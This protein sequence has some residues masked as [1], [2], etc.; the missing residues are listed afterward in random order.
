MDNM[1]GI[2]NPSPRFFFSSW[3]AE[4]HNGENLET[5][6]QTHRVVCQGINNECKLSFDPRKEK[7]LCEGACR[8]NTFCTEL[9][10]LKDVAIRKEGRTENPRAGSHFLFRKF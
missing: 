2:H 5:R 8:R 7:Y 6:D 1:P 9:R 3:K 4:G 10:I